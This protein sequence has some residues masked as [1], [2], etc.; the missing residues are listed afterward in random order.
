M[1][2]PAICSASATAWR[3]ASTVESMLT[4]IP[5]RNPR[6]GAAPTPPP[7]RPPPRRGAAPM[8]PPL[9]VP[10]SRPA[11]S[12]AAR[13]GTRG[14]TALRSSPSTRPSSSIQCSRAACTSVKGRRSS[15]T[16]VTRLGSSRTTSARRISGNADTRAA[17]APPSRVHRFVPGTMAAAA[18]IRGTGTREAPCTSMPAIAKRGGG[19]AQRAPASVAATPAS[20]TPRTTARRANRA[21]ARARR[22][23][24]R[25]GPTRW[26][27]T[28]GVRPKR[29]ASAPAPPRGESRPLLTEDADRGLERDSEV[30][31]N[32]LARELHEV[33]DVGG[34][35]GAAVDDEV[36][37]LGGD[38][39]AI[40][41]LAAQ[42]G[43]LDE[44]R[45]QVAGGIFPDEAGGGQRQRL[46]GLLLLEPCPDLFLDLRQRPAVELQ[47]AADEYRARRQAKRAIAELARG[48][49]LAERA[50]GVEVVNGAHEIADPAVGGARVHRQRAAD[51]GR[52]ADE[53]L[54][55]AKAEGGRLADE[56]GE[57]HARTRQRLLA[58]VFGAAE[59]ALELE[60]H[61]ANAAV[62]HHEVVAAADDGH[63]QLLALGEHQRMPDV[64]DVLGDDEDVG[65]AADAQRGVEAQR[66]FEPHFPPDL[67]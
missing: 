34:A 37:V 43:L 7:S 8:P 40:D 62:A 6:D 23:R 66:F 38:L 65:G 25:A 11:I 55:A 41:A 59:A 54:D 63:R 10:T 48:L 9:V 52:N 21:R 35:G 50:V 31:V 29:S 24:R 36:G 42:P 45:G 60:H 44:P 46:R 61:A 49:E 26:P 28:S 2:T 16:I 22:A 58:V 53:A 14:T 27:S 47:P 64:L 3:I 57:T 39:R 30:A 67:S 1:S 13:T 20:T 15:T 12:C 18:R 56:R 4:T 5:R 17:T 33:Q 19:V 51:G 32:A